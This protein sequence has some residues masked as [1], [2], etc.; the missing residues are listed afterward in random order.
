MLSPGDRQ[1]VP[2]HCSEPRTICLDKPISR[3]ALLRG[4]IK[5]LGLEE[6]DVRELSGHVAAVSPVVARPLR[7]L[8]VEDMLANQKLVT[9]ILEKRG[10]RVEVAGDGRQAL[11]QLQRAS[12]DA[13][14]MDVQMPVMDGFEATEAIRALSDPLLARIPII[15]MT[16][17]AMKGDAERCLAVGMTAYLSKPINSREMIVLLES[18]CEGNDQ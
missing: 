3:S 15:A 7:V 12:F 6:H 9:R 17:H 5:G 16:A 18:L 13:V 2:T 8:L 4:V 1:K 10:H 11:E 14:L